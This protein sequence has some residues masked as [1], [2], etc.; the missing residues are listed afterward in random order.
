M[1]N[2]GHK[3]S[4]A[5]KW[6]MTIATASLVGVLSIMI[7]LFLAV[8]NQAEIA[9]NVAAQH[10]EELLAIRTELALIRTDLRKETRD[11]YFRRDAERDHE[12]IELRIEKLEVK[13]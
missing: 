5:T 12:R 7:N 9:I 11:R 8:S 10:G 1:N 4:S 13:H 2:N 3:P 6:F